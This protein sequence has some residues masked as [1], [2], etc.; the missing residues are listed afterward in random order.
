MYMYIHTYM[1][2]YLPGA[3]PTIVRHNATSSLVRFEMKNIFFY[4][5]KNALA[6]YSDGVVVVNSEVVGLCP[7]FFHQGGMWPLKRN[8]NMHVHRYV[9]QNKT[10][11]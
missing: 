5:E 6:Y 2:I 11:H 1:H 9:L 10:R 8:K 3:N 7:I 4:F